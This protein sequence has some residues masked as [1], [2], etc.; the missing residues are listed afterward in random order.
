M[1]FYAVNG[2]NKEEKMAK[3]LVAVE[4]ERAYPY[5]TIKFV[6]L[7]T[8]MNQVQKINLMK[9]YKNKAIS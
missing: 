4:R 2:K 5:K 1:L 6:Y 3:T 8:H 7:I 9:K